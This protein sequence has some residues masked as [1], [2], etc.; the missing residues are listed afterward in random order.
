MKSLTQFSSAVLLAAVTIYS[1]GV[2]AQ[3][4]SAT[5]PAACTQVGQTVT[6]T[7]TTTFNVPNSL[8]LQGQ[9]GGGSF[10][11]TSG[12][13]TPVAPSG[14]AVSPASQ[15]VTIGS[16]PTLNVSCAIGSGSY[17]FQW[18][19]NGVNISNA[20]SQ[21]YTLSPS[22]DTGTPNSASYTVVVTN[23]AGSAPP[24]APASV[25][26][27]TQSVTAP[28]SCSVTPASTTVSVGAT[29]T[30]S[31][32][33]ASGTAPFG[34]TWYKGS[35]QISG[36]NSSSYTLTSSDTASAGSQTYRVDVANSAGTSS[37]SG[38]VNV[39]AASACSNSGSSVNSVIDVNTVYKQVG[40]SNL[41]GTANT[42]V[43][44]LDVSASASTVG[45]LTALL[46]HTEGVGSQ[47]AF[48]TVALSPCIGD[49][50]SSAAVLLSTN[51]VGSTI[52]LAINDPGRGYPNLTTGTWYV[53]IKNTACT[54]N[55][56]CDTLV[57]WL[58][59]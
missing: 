31:A 16:S 7:T 58:H 45:G 52:D 3:S 39:N 14:C 8:N 23:S 57:D 35:A 2:N 41:F 12:A 15:S 17:T 43:I 30:L 4:A 29:Q 24:A 38:T 11:L 47:R 51:S 21:T 32:S 25:T 55:T 34:Y 9:T 53:N 59:Y 6:C 28:S 19:K 10:T 42:Y 5:S 33:C 22:T 49:F 56:R 20:T 18:S 48:R 50:T 44:R 46:S 37:A 26:V 36:A 1:S 13:V 54:A 40:S 27:S